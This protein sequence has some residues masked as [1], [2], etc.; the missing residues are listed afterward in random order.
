MSLADGQQCLDH[1]SLSIELD[2]AV[3]DSRLGRYHKAAERLEAL[4]IS[5]TGTG[6]P[7]IA[8]GIERATLYISQG[9]Y[10]LAH[11]AAYECAQMTRS[12]NF[13]AVEKQ[14]HSLLKNLAEV[15]CFVA[16]MHVEK[17]EFPAMEAWHV[18][19]TALQSIDKNG[20]EESSHRPYVSHISSLLV[21]SGAAEHKPPQG[22]FGIETQ[23]HCSDSPQLQKSGISRNEDHDR[24]VLF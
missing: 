7:E 18:C 24:P 22:P 12:P 3:Q 23:Y 5:W 20:L 16:A 14:Y 11:A 6:W 1:A 10:S 8:I 2:A 15:T 21:M 17:I 19:L 4:K 13:P 9:L